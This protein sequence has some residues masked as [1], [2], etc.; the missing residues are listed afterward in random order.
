MKGAAG[1]WLANE[2]KKAADAEED[3]ELSAAAAV[4]LPEDEEDGSPSPAPAS[5]ASS[6]PA[7]A[8]S[9]PSPAEEVRPKWAAVDNAASRA[10]LAERLG[11]VR[12]LSVMALTHGM[13]RD[14]RARVRLADAALPLLLRGDGREIPRGFDSSHERLGGARQPARVE[15]QEA[16]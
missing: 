16:R 9:S 10:A 5:S 7:S 2:E 14:R 1:E 12:V 15:W 13:R 4:P 11:A 6:A 3:D 8:S